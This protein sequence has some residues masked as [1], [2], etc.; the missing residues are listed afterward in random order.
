MNM[1]DMG[2]LLP[3][4]SVPQGDIA[5]ELC[6]LSKVYSVMPFG[7]TNA[8]S[9]AL[10]WA[11]AGSASRLLSSAAAMPAEEARKGDME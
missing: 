1:D 8:P 10:G 2:S 7:P 6:A 3:S 9:A 5:L 11:N 4:G